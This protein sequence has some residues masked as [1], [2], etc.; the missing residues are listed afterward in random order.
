LPIANELYSGNLLYDGSYIFIPLEMAQDML[1]MTER[2]RVAPGFNP[3]TVIM[4][5]T[6]DAA[7]GEIEVVGQRPARVT[8]VV[9]RGAEGAAPEAVRGAVTQI[10]TDFAARHVGEVPPAQER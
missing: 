1:R 6:G 9:V 5:E 4:D 8:T 10:W 7:D 2:G 3:A